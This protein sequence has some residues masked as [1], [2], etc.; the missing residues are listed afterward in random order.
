MHKRVDLW[1]SHNKHISTWE[2]K[3]QERVTKL[4]FANCESHTLLE[5][6]VS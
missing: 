4:L 6:V 2:S 5:M 1:P 3:G